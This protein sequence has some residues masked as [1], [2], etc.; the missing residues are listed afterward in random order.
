MSKKYEVKRVE[1]KSDRKK[2]I[3]FP[4][5]VYR[6]DPNWV[7]PIMMEYKKM[8]TPGKH[9]YYEHGEV[10]FFMVFR[11][12]ELVGRTTAHTNTIHNEVHRDKIGFFG[13]F[14]CQNDRDATRA[15]FDAAGEWLRKKGMDTI[16]GPLSFSQ[17]EIAGLLI[18][19]FD[20]PAVFEMAYNPPYFMT[21]KV[22]RSDSGRAKITIKAP[23]MLRNRT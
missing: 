5:T 18:D 4:F 15:L 1:T 16:R 11:D 2:F 13:F 8:L 3:R 10:E 19:A 12:G 7:P 22:K 14:E 20:T 23:R 21:I 6:N 9:P 17:N